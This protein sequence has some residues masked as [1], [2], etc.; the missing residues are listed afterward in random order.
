[1]AVHPSCR[2][3]PL[4]ALG[5][6]IVLLAGACRDT[7]APSAPPS[8]VPPALAATAALHWRQIDV[9]FG[10]AC[11][12][13]TDSVAYCWGENSVG[14]VGDGTKTRRL[15]PR[16]VLGNL[17]FRH[18]AT[19]VAYACGVTS[20]FKAYCWGFNNR[21]QL[22]DGTSTNRLS[23]TLV[24]GGHQFKQIRAGYSHTCAP[25]TDGKA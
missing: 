15:T 3:R 9:G 11:G 13:T 19:G 22:S 2:C 1:M 5:A 12:T 4:P 24:L 8:A 6:G 21:G 16:Q 14:A 20:D 17:R 25:T 23:P 7:T 18:V 10:N